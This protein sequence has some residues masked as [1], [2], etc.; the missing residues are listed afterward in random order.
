MSDS[1]GTSS[2]IHSSNNVLHTNFGS[3]VQAKLPDE[4]PPRWHRGCYSKYSVGICRVA[5]CPY[6]HDL[7][8][9][10]AQRLLDWKKENQRHLVFTCRSTPNSDTDASDSSNGSDRQ[11]HEAS[12]IAELIESAALIPSMG[13]Q[14]QQLIRKLKEHF[15]D[16]DDDELRKLLPSDDADRETSIGSLFHDSGRCRPCRN[17]LAGQ[18]CSK[19]IRCGFCHYPHDQ[20]PAS[21]VDTDFSDRRRSGT[22]PCKTQRDKY[23]KHVERIEEQIR[24]NPWSFDTATVH[25]PPNIFDGRPELK[26]K[27]MMRLSGLVDL[28]KAECLAAG[29]AGRPLSSHEALPSL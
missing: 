8:P 15:I 9:G 13:P 7:T 22:R 26:N 14:R 25:L 4:P 1:E 2:S 18:V 28:A 10:D 23:R 20:V 16:V 12:S 11:P 17:M 3:F 19:G 5:H 29:Q 24:A 6:F 21:A 27:F